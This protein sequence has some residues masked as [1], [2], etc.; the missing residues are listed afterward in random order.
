MSGMEWIK[1]PTLYIDNPQLGRLPEVIQARFFKLYMLAG[2]CD[3]DG[4]IPLSEE[5]IAWKLHISLE[6][7]QETTKILKN[8]T[9]VLYCCNGRGPE[10]PVFIQEQ[11]SKEKRDNHRENNRERQEKYREEHKRISNVL[12]SPKSQSQSQ[13]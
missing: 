10:V 1:L 11:V 6:E 8:T 13:S 2:Q 5:E 3:Q 4:L 12:L 9:P 7:L